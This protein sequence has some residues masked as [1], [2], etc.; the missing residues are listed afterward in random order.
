MPKAN[1]HDTSVV[2][3]VVGFVIV[4]KL[5]KVKICQFFFTYYHKKICLCT[6]C[7]CPQTSF[8]AK[9]FTQHCA[10]SINFKKN[11]PTNCE[12]LLCLV[13]MF[14]SQACW[15]YEDSGGS[16]RASTSTIPKFARMRTLF[17]SVP[18]HS[19]TICELVK[20]CPML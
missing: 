3:F 8:K 10:F 19:R 15:L 17:P 2:G 4:A 14:F 6:P 16:L 13:R 20:K 1:R 12:N 7:T 5:K 11:E 18:I 9:L